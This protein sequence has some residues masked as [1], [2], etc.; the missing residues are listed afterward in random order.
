MQSTTEAILTINQ[1]YYRQKVQ[2][3]IL[4]ILKSNQLLSSP[5]MWKIEKF[6]EKFLG[7][8]KKPPS[9][10]EFCFLNQAVNNILLTNGH[11]QLLRI[12]LAKPRVQKS[13]SILI[14]ETLIKLNGKDSSLEKWLFDSIYEKVCMY[15]KYLIKVQRPNHHAI[16]QDNVPNSYRYNSN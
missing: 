11:W 16:Y 15:I 3:L 12:P 6:D 8:D 2:H 10:M 14:I 5:S 1:C 7:K 9:F 4:K 13:F